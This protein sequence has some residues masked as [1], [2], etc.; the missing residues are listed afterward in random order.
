VV[1]LPARAAV[2]DDHVDWE[3]TVAWSLQP[4]STGLAWHLLGTRTPEVLHWTAWI[5]LRAAADPVALSFA[6]QFSGE[7][8][9]A[10]EVSVDD[11]NWQ[12]LAVVP[13][14][15]E[16]S[17]LAFDLSA[18][19]GSLLQLRFVW[20]PGD[21]SASVNWWLDR[22]QVA[23]VPP[24]PPDV[25]AAVPTETVGNTEPTPHPVMNEPITEPDR[26]L[27][28]ALPCRLD[29]DTDGEITEADF[30]LIADEVF[31]RAEIQVE[32]YDLNGDRRID[33]GD[34]QMMA[35]YWSTRCP[36]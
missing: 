22:I 24:T 1:T 6:T 25:P 9:A 32:A 36:E 10:I 15:P 20:Q 28:A 8:S 4:R 35:Q 2:G 27:V 33:I 30:A 5:D 12:L 7:G 17:V 13:V 3:Y 16:W 11:V 14:I 23:E 31:D 19:R 29:V 21:A 18:F 34:M 26:P